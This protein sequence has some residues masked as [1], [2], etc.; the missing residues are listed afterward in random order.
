[1]FNNIYIYI[2]IYIYKKLGFSFSFLVSFI[3][4]CIFSLL[5]FF[6]CLF[7]AAVL[8]IIAQKQNMCLTHD[9]ISM[10]VFTRNNLMNVVTLV[11]KT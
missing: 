2:Y 7:V 11:V 5:G 9:R 8:C 10:L 4:L 3:S 6:V 1:M